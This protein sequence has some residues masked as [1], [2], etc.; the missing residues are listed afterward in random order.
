MCPRLTT[1]TFSGI[2]GANRKFLAFEKK[3]KFAL[4]K[5]ISTSPTT[6]ELRPEKIISQSVIR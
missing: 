3:A 5:A 4:R 1:G 2:K 6:S